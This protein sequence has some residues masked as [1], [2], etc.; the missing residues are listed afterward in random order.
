MFAC[1]L[2]DLTKDEKNTAIDSLLNSGLIG[3]DGD[4]FV[5]E[6]IALIS[7]MQKTDRVILLRILANQEKGM[8]NRN[9]FE[10]LLD[11]SIEMDKVHLAQVME[12]ATK[13]PF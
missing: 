2:Y 11:E 5:I 13:Y 9:I 7:A 8:F 1:N 6:E 12:S 3:I 10:K 4:E